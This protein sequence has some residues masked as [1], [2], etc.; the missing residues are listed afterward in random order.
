[1]R[2][3]G[4]PIAFHKTYPGFATGNDAV[5]KRCSW[6][7]HEKGGQKNLT[8]EPSNFTHACYEKT[9]ILDF[10]LPAFERQLKVPHLP[11][12]HPKKFVVLDAVNG[13]LEYWV[14]H[15]D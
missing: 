2:L 13:G 11:V 10:A 8:A 6:Y 12:Y 15:L 7:T 5:L 4:A 14:L 3:T 9:N 1:M